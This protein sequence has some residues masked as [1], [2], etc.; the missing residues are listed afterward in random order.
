MRS[1]PLFFFASKQVLNQQHQRHARQSQ[2][3]RQYGRKRVDDRG[4]TEAAARQ[5]RQQQKA[6]SGVLDEAMLCRG[7]AGAYPA[8]ARSGFGWRD[9]VYAV[10]VALLAVLCAVL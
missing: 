4:Q 2:K 3:A 5:L 10:G 8:P 7:F 6:W 1:P 9:G